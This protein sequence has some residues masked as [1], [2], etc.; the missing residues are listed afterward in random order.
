M[1]LIIPEDTPPTGG[2]SIS[3]QRV[4][5]GLEQAGHEAYVIRYE[6]GIRG[7]D[8]YHAWNASR[9]GARLVEEGI[10]PE[11]IVAT[12]TGTDLWQDWVADPLAL[13]RRIAPIRYQ[14]TFTEDA[15]ARLLRDAPEW[16]SRLVVIP[17]SVDIEHFHPEGPREEAPHPLFLLAGG[18]RP[19]KRSA[20]AIDLVA[21]LRE[22]LHREYF[23]A[24][25]GP[26]REQG[27]WQ[28]VLQKARGR[29]WVRLLGDLSRT[30]M[31]RW[32][33]AADYFLN[34]S[35]VEGVS[36]AIMEAMS[37]AALVLATDIQG[38]RAL[39]DHGRTGLLFQD[40][41]DFIRQVE[42]IERDPEKRATLK[43]NA[44]RQI[45]GRHSLVH[46]VK[47]YER[48]YE[49]CVSVRGCCR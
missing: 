30:E 40:E 19:V 38:N 20:W 4:Q 26:V 31:P 44:R 33:R 8:V 10:N 35:A 25:A 6:P 1:A 48:L 29:A 37:S 36:N 43:A 22:R 18:V 23:L 32:Y 39:I 21:A 15:R 5:E 46:E 7:Y 14:V 3:A 2:N 42:A 47:R 11:Q 9:V 28:R 24:I 49:D 34:T 13:K 16:D 17:P 27:E 41:E 12:W 45:V